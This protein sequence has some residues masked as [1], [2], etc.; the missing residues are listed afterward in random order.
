MIAPITEV[1]EIITERSVPEA[2]TA[3]FE[4]LGIRVTRLT[5]AR[6]N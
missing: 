3:P 4:R 1:S 6:Q 2:A 5:E